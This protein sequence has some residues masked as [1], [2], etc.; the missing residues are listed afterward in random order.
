[1]RLFGLLLLILSCFG[2]GAGTGMVSHGPHFG[3]GISP[4]AI[5]TLTPNTVP[6]NSVPFTMMVNGSNFGADSIVFWNGVQQHTTFVS[7]TQLMADVTVVDLMMSGQIH[8][9]VRTGGMNTNTV[10]FVVAPQ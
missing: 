3:T 7:P 10:D 1:M 8:V 4:P 2:C 6:V 9:F 5:T